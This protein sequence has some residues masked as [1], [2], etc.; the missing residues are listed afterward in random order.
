MCF[1]SVSACPYFVHTPCM[2]TESLYTVDKNGIRNSELARIRKITTLLLWNQR[3]WI[4][5][6][7]FLSFRSISP[8]P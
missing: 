1:L 5:K 3:Y 8:K 2:Y 7:Q 4:G 6:K